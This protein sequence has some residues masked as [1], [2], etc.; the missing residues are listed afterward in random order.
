MAVVPT[1]PGESGSNAVS[2]AGLADF[3]A[4]EYLDWYVKRGGSKVKLV[5][6]TDSDRTTGFMHRVRDLAASRGYAA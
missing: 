6:S 5:M 3:W 4:S 1:G 2:V